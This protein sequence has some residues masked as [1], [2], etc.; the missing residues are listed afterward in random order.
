MKAVMVMFDSLNRNYLSVYGDRISHTPN[1]ERLAAHSAQFRNS[2]VCSMP[3]IPARRDLHTGRP[4]FLHRSWGPLEPFDNSF[5]AQLRTA[6]IPAHLSTDHL[7]YWND[8]GVNYHTKYSSYHLSRGRCGDPCLAFPAQPRSPSEV[9]PAAAKAMPTITGIDWFNRASQQDTKDF[10]QVK[11]FDAGVDFLDRCHG[12]DPWFLQIETFDPHEPFHAPGDLR[13][14]FPEA[15]EDPLFDWPAYRRVEESPERVETCRANYRA[16]LALC[17]SQ[18]GRVLD[19][20]DR[21]DLWQDTMLIVWTDHGFLL[22]EHELWAKMWCPF[23]NEIA[24][25]PFFVWDPRSGAV[26]E[27]REAL[28]QPAIDLAPTLLRFFGLPVPDEVTG[29][30]LASTVAADMPVREAAMFGTF[31]AHLNVTDGR[32]VYFRA[33]KEAAGVRYEYT[34]MPA[35]SSGLM[36]AAALKDAGWHSPLS[37]TKGMPVMRIPQCPPHAHASAWGNLLFDLKTDPSQQNPISAP[38]IE[39]KLTR[40]LVHEMERCDAP[41]EV[42]P[43]YGLTCPISSGNGPQASP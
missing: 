41:P 16:L 39:E 18:L 15:L 40:L 5:P 38:D 1:F 19:A 35:N 29:Y 37:F 31:A 13:A 9:N 30:D 43:H 2:Y 32:H 14:M 25:T 7:H 10:P 34:L 24:R 27:T 20:F 22:G 12:A 36:A 17:D 8:G 4:G 6:G 21:H 3:C 11:T 23:Y 28:V 42:Y 26:G 33:P